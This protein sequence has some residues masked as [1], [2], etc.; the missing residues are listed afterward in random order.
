M[1]P[2]IGKECLLFVVVNMQTLGVDLKMDIQIKE[3]L[4]LY[5]HGQ[6]VH[7]DQL[8]GH[9]HHTIIL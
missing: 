1:I 4:R 7:Q 5:H 3:G 6:G 2:G 9:I 8:N